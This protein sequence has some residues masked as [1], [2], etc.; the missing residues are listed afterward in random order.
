MKKIMTYF[1]LLILPLLL[2]YGYW[3]RQQLKSNYKF[4]I[5]TTTK[6]TWVNKMR[7]IRYTYSFSRR[8][9]EADYSEDERINI[10]YPN[11]RYLIKFSLSHPDITKVYW[12]IPIP[13][14]IV[15][16][17][18]SGWTKPPFPFDSVLIS[19]D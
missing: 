1:G 2:I 5:G 3:W 14:S 6:R 10:R 15:S 9:L 16:A 4:T 8:K 19:E 7:K 13:D 18:D 12:K 17:P 11:G